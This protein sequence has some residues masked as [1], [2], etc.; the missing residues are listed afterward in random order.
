[1]KN[2][3]FVKE[4]LKR[5]CRN[6]F[7]SG[8]LLV[9]FTSLK[10]QTVSNYSF[11]Q[12]SGTYT[13]ITGGTNMVL[14]SNATSA[15]DSQFFHNG[16]GGVNGTTA[17]GTFAAFPIG[18]N[19][20]YNGT[21]YDGF[22]MSTDGALRLASV[23]PSSIGSLGGTIP[24]SSTTAT[25]INLISAFGADLIGGIR[26]ANLTRTS[27]SDV[28]NLTGTST[29][30]ASMITPGMRVIGAGI[31]AGATVVS[32]TGSDVTIS[33]NA[34]AT[35]TAGSATFVD[36][37]NISYVTT[38]T[39]G[40]QVLTVQWKNVSRFS[41][42]GD[43]LN[44]QIKLYE[45]TNAI[46]VIYDTSASTQVTTASTIQV[47]LKGSSTTDFNNRLGT[48]ATA[49]SA[50]SLG[51]LNSST[52]AFQ[53]S[54]ATGGAI[55]PASGL[56]FTWTPPM[57]CTGAPIAGTV[58]P[59][60]QSLMPGQTPANLV[61]SGFSSGVAGLA[62]QWEQSS[63]NNTWSNVVGGTGATTTTYTPPAYT[64]TA[65][66]YRCKVTCTNSST[67]SFTTSVLV[68]S[69]AAVSAPFSETFSGGVL[70]SCWVSQNPTTTSTNANVRWKFTGNADYGAS[71]ANNGRASGTYA[72][73]DASSPYD[74]EHT[75]ELLSPQINLTGLNAPYVSFEWF[76]NH[77]TSASTTVSPSTYDNNKL[78]VDINDGNGW[79]TIFT[80]TT[81][82]QTWRTE[83]ITLASSYIGA[84]V[85]FRFT[86]DKD[87]SGNGYFY[88]DV[89]LDNV[90][91][92]EAPACFV[93]QNPTIVSVTSSSANISWAAPSTVPSNG[94]QVYYSAINTAPTATTVLD[95]TN[96]VSS[97]TTTATISGLTANTNYY[98]W[99]RSN[100]GSA[101]TSAWSTSLNVYTGYCTPAPSSVDGSG[102]TNV[103]FGNLPNV[104]NNTTVAETGNYGNYSTMIGDVPAGVASQ[105]S[106]TYATGYTYDTKIWVDL[107]NNLV[108]EDAEALY[109]GTST[110][111][112]PTTLAASITIPASTP[113]GTYRMRIGGQDV[114]PATP[115]YNG[116][117]GTFE[118]YTVNVTA[119]P[120]CLPPSGLASSSVASTG[121]TISWT[122]PATAP[123]NGYE[124]AYS[125]TNTAPASGTATTATSVPLSSLTPSTT[126][127]YWVRSNCGG[128][129]STW[130]SGS[131]TTL[132]AP[133]ANDNCSGAVSLTPG[134]TFAQN[135][136]TGTTIGATLTNDTTATTAACQTTRFADT[137]YSV[138]VPPS[139]SI[140]IETKSAAGSAVTNTVL[141]VYT[142]S[143]GAL[144]S[145][146]C[147][148]D[149]GDGNFSILSL[150]SANGITP[151]Q[152]LLIGVW[153]YSS[154]NNGTFQISAYDASLSTSE[155]VIS[156]NEIKAYPNPFSDVLNI[157]DIKNVKSISVIDIAGRVVK[158][159]DKPTAALQLSELNSGM[160]LVVLNMN[161]GTKQ[162]L[163]AIKK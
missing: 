43:R 99:V 34:T 108:F 149:D 150:T 161:D 48:G 102:I 56:K 74:N 66:Y 107:N 33:A 153:N 70:P 55:V 109:T 163:K 93:P 44:F 146:G 6:L 58:S 59:A 101:S 75:V 111:T 135:A 49:W 142:G 114:G 76:K 77:S 119:A 120:S 140:T 19:F 79:V 23:T 8:L 98:V 80:G 20:N 139:G 16:T 132:A 91:V 103:T 84:T 72:W 144:T 62:F 90:E 42:S 157:S 15:W 155:A 118:D 148:D 147:N 27:G 127:Y 18:F 68:G 22:Y 17:A 113:L 41:G 45:G 60:S 73:V 160:Y 51:T 89:L 162:T 40:S 30:V 82:A 83:G 116:T 32:V 141:G 10:A 115:C 12:S 154:T 100:C 159:F 47:G 5:T 87:V 130:V 81:N 11:S 67:D 95:A 104:V 57:A 46:E 37:D 14:L 3:S 117:Y 137:W 54:A 106:I 21:V 63:D 7:L 25:A 86:V 121:A 129:T 138:V 125:T 134:A 96:S 128:S 110:S 71:L 38:G 28:L 61:L 36:I 136:I 64:G 39:P 97:T 158:S 122:A 92:K 123:T 78:T 24:I 126:Y 88:D 31:P 105:V 29:A 26:A 53:G 112:N 131:F 4:K 85:Q 94:Y 143:C 133:P 65:I 13:P 52:I 69:C 1:M 2:F 152:T 50:S 151:G 156:K 124:Y 35:S 145:V 9:S